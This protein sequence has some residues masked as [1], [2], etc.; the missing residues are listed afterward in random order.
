VP[1]KDGRWARSQLPETGVGTYAS[2]VDDRQFIV[3][4][5]ALSALSVMLLGLAL[6]VV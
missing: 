5:V 6:F 4:I 1:E 2:S 3:L